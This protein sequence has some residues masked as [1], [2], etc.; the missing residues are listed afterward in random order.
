MGRSELPLSP[1]KI[2]CFDL[3][4]LVKSAEELKRKNRQVYLTPFLKDPSRW[5]SHYCFEPRP[6][7]FTC[8]ET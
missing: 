6:I 7:G 4:A 5:L 8:S 1:E 2:T 3:E